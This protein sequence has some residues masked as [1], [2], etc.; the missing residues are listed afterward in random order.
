MRVEIVK[1]TKL[2]H[3][4]SIILETQEEIDKIYALLQHTQ[5]TKPLDLDV[6]I[7]SSPW[8]R[9]F[10]MLSCLSSHDNVFW[11]NKITEQLD[12]KV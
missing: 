5:I 10:D 9:L 4:I 7:I 8:G 12:K 11:F 2:E 1:Q 3:P 6:T